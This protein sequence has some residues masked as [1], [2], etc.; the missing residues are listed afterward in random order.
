MFIMGWLF[1]IACG[2]AKDWLCIGGYAEGPM[3]WGMYML[4][5]GPCWPNCVPGGM[6]CI[7]VGGMFCP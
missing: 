1:I 7:E 6:D 3:V 2:P 4:P 5:P